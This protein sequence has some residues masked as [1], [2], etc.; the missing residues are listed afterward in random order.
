MCN[1]GPCQITV[2]EGV[3]RVWG[4]TSVLPFI[5][6]V[7]RCWSIH[8]MIIYSRIHILC[9]FY[10]KKHDKREDTFLY[11]WNS[12][13]SLKKFYIWK[14]WTSSSMAKKIAKSNNHRNNNDPVFR[15]MQNKITEIKY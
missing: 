1:S 5:N 4:A 12:S 15:K 2:L 8:Y 7:A 9:I 3:N 10:D 6:M 14:K 13:I 11:G